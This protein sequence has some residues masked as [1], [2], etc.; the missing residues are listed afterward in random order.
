MFLIRI[1][2]IR[3]PNLKHKMRGIMNRNDTTEK[4]TAGGEVVERTLL[5]SSSSDRE[6]HVEGKRY[7]YHSTRINKNNDANSLNRKQED[8]TLTFDR[9]TTTSKTPENM[10]PN[11]E[12]NKDTNIEKWKIDKEKKDIDRRNSTEISEVQW[13]T[14]KRAQNKRKAEGINQEQDSE[15][16]RTFIYVVGAKRW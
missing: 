14:P 15:I 8:E 16:K 3:K 7:S 10:E 11:S 2:R 6:E 9:I 1:I 12:T 13:E 4:S 5:R